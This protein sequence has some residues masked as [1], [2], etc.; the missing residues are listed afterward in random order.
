ME[1]FKDNQEIKVIMEEI[2]IKLCLI[3][4]N[5]LDDVIWRANGGGGGG[6]DWC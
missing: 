3:L 4:I 1:T 2:E 6:C 5:K